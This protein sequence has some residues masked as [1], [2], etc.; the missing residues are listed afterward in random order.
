MIIN[1]SRIIAFTCITS[2]VG[3]ITS[4]VKPKQED[5][6]SPKF[7]VSL[8]F[9]TAKSVMVFPVEREGEI[10]SFV[11]DTGADATLIQRDSLVGKQESVTGTSK[12]EMLLGKEIIPTLSIAGVNFRQVQAFNGNLRGL[13]EQIPNF[14]GLIG[15]SIISKACWL[16]DYPNRQLSMASQNLADTSFC[17]LK[18]FAKKGKPYVTLIIDG[19]KYDALVDLGST[20]CVSISKES[21]LA[22]TILRKYPV[23][24]NTRDIYS[25]GGLQKVTEK[26]GVLPTVQIGET[27]FTDVAFDIRSTSGLRVGMRFFTQYAIHINGFDGTYK[28]KRLPGKDH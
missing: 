8:P 16:I 1:L 9:T 4:N 3:C 18:A 12:R 17:D 7:S 10:R 25:L 14:G 5:A 27:A 22:K 26:V 20:A 11:F 6:A 21:D 13:K 24:D 19:K 23:K 28:V 15:Q 2:L